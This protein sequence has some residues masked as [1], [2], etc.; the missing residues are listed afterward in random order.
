MH[1]LAI[2]PCNLQPRGTCRRQTGTALGFALVRQRATLTGAAAQRPNTNRVVLEGEGST[3]ASLLV[4]ACSGTHTADSLSLQSCSECAGCSG[5]RGGGV[6]GIPAETGRPRLQLKSYMGK[7]AAFCSPLLPQPAM[8]RQVFL[9]STVFVWRHFLNRRI[10]LVEAIR[11][12]SEDDDPDR[13]G[14]YPRRV[15]SI[16]SEQRPKRQT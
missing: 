6:A 7:A 11:G 10:E 16:S 1:G 9:T 2:T 14:L 4:L 3:T 15:N 8:W 5:R 13:K 12:V